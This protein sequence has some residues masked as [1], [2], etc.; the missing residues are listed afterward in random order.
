M[1]PPLR[2]RARFRPS[3]A[4]LALAIHGCGCRDER[5]YTWS[6]NSR[7]CV[8]ADQAT[9]SV[10][11]LH[12]VCA[13]EE[14]PGSTERNAGQRPGLA[15]RAQPCARGQRVPQKTDPLIVPFGT[16]ESGPPRCHQAWQGGPRGKGEKAGQEPTALP[17]TGG[18]RKTSFGAKPSSRGLLA[19]RLRKR[20]HP[21]GRL[22]EGAGDRGPER[23]GG[24]RQNPAYRSAL[25]SGM[26]MC[27]S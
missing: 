7:S 22:H 12:R 8:R 13:G 3:L 15:R 21:A 6:S 20:R 11:V 16:R 17:A 25:F 1:L 27:C 26:K 4:S 23:D 10:H 2:G 19:G 18:A 9:A 5:I 14:S 24:P